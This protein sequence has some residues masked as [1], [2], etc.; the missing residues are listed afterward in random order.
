[1]NSRVTSETAQP[2]AMHYWHI[3]RRYRGT[4]LLTSLLG[5]AAG[6]ATSFLQTP[7]YRARTSVEIQSL[8]E[9]F[10]NMADVNTV[11]TAPAYRDLDLQTQLQLLQSESLIERVVT[12]L[13]LE[14]PFTAP[15]TPSGVSGQALALPTPAAAAVARANRESSP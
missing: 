1:M 13:K 6:L 3:L 11:A 9:N 4:M 5:V 8:N 15:P 12:K 14:R 10:L 2:G 7:V